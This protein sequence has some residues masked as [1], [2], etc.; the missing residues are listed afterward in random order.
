MIKFLQNSFRNKLT[1]S[2]LAVFFLIFFFSSFFISGSIHKWAHSNLKDSLKNQAILV[3]QNLINLIQ[4]NKPNQLQEEVRRLGAL[5]SLRITVINA[6]GVV[7]ADSM[8]D[9][10]GVQNMDDH[11]QRSEVLEAF[12]GNVGMSTR[13]SFTLKK[14][15][16]YV[17]IPYYPEDGIIG[18][19]RV[20][21]PLRD[22]KRMTRGA[23]NS[24][25][26]SVVVGLAI[27]LI[28]G[29]A[30]SGFW[31]KRLAI[32][33]RSALRYSWGEFDEKVHINTRDEWR[34]LGDAM[35]RMAKALKE[36]IQGISDEKEKLSAILNYINEG[37]FAVDREKRVV[38]MNPRVREMMSLEEKE[39][40][41]KSLLQVTQNPKLDQL[42]SDVLVGDQILS[43]EMEIPVGSGRVFQVHLISIQSGDD[44]IAGMVV[45]YEITSF[46]KLQKMRQEFVANVS[47]ELKTPLTSIQGFIETLRGGAL[48]DKEKAQEFLKII[49]EDTERL[50][51]L[52][53]DL[54]ELSKLD[55]REDA[56]SLEPLRLDQEVGSVLSVFQNSLNKKNLKVQKDFFQEEITVKAEQDKI[57]QV[58]VNFLDNAIKYSPENG[59][60]YLSIKDQNN[61]I[62]VSI[63]DEGPGI[64]PEALP[65]LFERFYRVDDA[66][67]R[68]LGGTGLGLAIVKHIVVSHHGNV[69]CHSELGQ[70]STFSFT[71][72]KI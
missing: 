11:S 18:V 2:Y 71:L 57:R 65:R 4:I 8:L 55:S 31:S 39:V 6:H 36:M 26:I 49:S 54:L 9:L 19:I 13:Y 42:M 38:L 32:L 44:N 14:E 46:R 66:R 43:E 10:E 62:E 60:I 25:W 72:P 5:L 29:F 1:F 21:K 27:V 15:M 59:N 64:P 48:E 50:N 37:V 16:F 33:T 24:I 52:I 22:V 40:L 69:Y 51:R 30:L 41:G 61:F 3:K 67:S 70:G 12:K 45:F 53:D 34:L 47:H 23:R 20:S 17:A 28:V 56:L 35:N 68:E 58:L 63:Q 7:L